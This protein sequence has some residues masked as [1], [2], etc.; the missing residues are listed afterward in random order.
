MDTKKASFAELCLAAVCAAA[1]TI[2]LGVLG[3]NVLRSYGFVLFLILP[4][5]MGF[6]AGR[7]LSL[8]LPR[9]LGDCEKA[10]FLAVFFAGIGLVFFGIEGLICLLMAFPLVL[11]FALLGSSLAYALQSRLRRRNRALATLLLAVLC[12]PLLLGA[13]AAVDPQPPLLE[14]Y[15]AIEID[16]PPEVVWRHVISFSEL[17]PPEEWIFRAGIAYP[18]RAEIEGSGPGAVRNCVFSTGA[19]VEPIEVWSEP[20]LLRFTVTKNPPSMVELSPYASIKPPH[21][22]GF[23]VSE[24]GA[25]RGWRG[26]R[27]ERPGEGR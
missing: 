18:I 20:V 16:A 21:I 15:T 24:K 17:P 27:V 19:F 11:P 12:A 23:F 3:T 5:L 10:A 2:A 6:V 25:S 4:V 1:L 13:E 7:L 22:E 26:H 9:P 14:A 8:R